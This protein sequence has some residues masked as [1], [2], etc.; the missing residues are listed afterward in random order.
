MSEALVFFINGRQI[1][2]NSPDPG[3]NLLNYLR[4][5]LQLTGTKYGC[6][7]GGCGACTVMISRYDLRT[8][9]IIHES[10]YACLVPICAVHGMAITTVEGIGNANKL[11]PVQERLAK[12]HGSQ[13]GFCSPGM[14]MSMYTLLRNNPQP[15]AMEIEDALQGNLCRCTG[16]RPIL[17]GFQKFAKIEEGC[18]GNSEN[19]CGQAKFFS[20]ENGDVVDDV[21]GHT[22]DNDVGIE[23]YDN[24]FIPFDPSQEPIFPPELMLNKDYH[25]KSVTFAKNGLVWS[26]PT[27]L[28]ELLQIRARNPVAR[29]VS[30]NLDIGLK[31]MITGTINPTVICVTHVP[32]MTN[33]EISG[34]GVKFGASVTLATINDFYR[35]KLC[36]G[37]S[38]QLGLFVAFLEMAKSFGQQ[39]RNK[40]GIGS[41]VMAASPLSDLI[42]IMMAAGC[43][44]NITSSN[45]PLR[46]VP[47]TSAFFTDYHVTAIEQDEVL[48]SVT[49]PFTT[50]NEYCHGYKVQKLLHRRDDSVTALN[51]GMYVAFEDDQTTLKNIRLCFGGV[52]KTVKTATKTTKALI[53]RYWD[54][55]LLNDTLQ[56]LVGELQLLGDSVEYRRSL[57]QGFFFKFYWYVFNEIASTAGID[58]I[59]LNV[60][61]AIEPQ[62]RHPLQSKQSYQKIASGEGNSDPVGRP[63][64]HRSGIQQATG[65]A[66]YCDD[67]TQEKGELHMAFVLSIFAHAK[68]IS[69]DATKALDLPGVKCFLSADDIPRVDNVFAPKKVVY[70]GQLVG[71]IAAESKEIAERAVKVVEVKYE[72]L[73]A[74]ISIKDAIAKN[75]VDPDIWKYETGDVE[76]EFERSDH[77]MAGEIMLGTQE[78]FYMETTSCICRPR[79]IDE[80]EVIC[81]TQWP[82]SLQMNVAAALGVPAHKVSCKVKRIGGAFGGKVNRP[83]AFAAS[84]AVAARKLNRTVRVVLSRDTDM[85]ATTRRVPMMAKYKVGYTTDGRVRALDISIIGNAGGDKTIGEPIEGVKQAISAVDQVYRI[86]HFRGTGAVCITNIPPTGP[87]RGF[88]VPSGNMFCETIIHDIAVKCGISQEQM[89]EVNMYSC[90]DK[91]NHFNQLLNQVGNIRRCWDECLQVSNFHQRRAAVDAY[92]RENRW[93]KRG[94]SIN[95][96]KRKCGFPGGFLNQGGALVQVYTDGSVLISHG[97][98]EM[99]QGLYTKTIQVASRVLHIPIDRIHANETATDKNAN[100][101]ITGGGVG[102]DLFGNAVKIACESIMDK[103]QPTMAENPKGS[104][105]EWVK[106]A[107]DNRVDL[108]ARGFYKPPGDPMNWTERTGAVGYYFAYGCAC[109]EVEVDCLTGDFEVL[110]TDIVVD[111][112]D[113]LNPAL[114]IGQIEGG[115]MQGYGLFTMEE[116]RRSA[117]GELLSLGPGLY[118]IP[119]VKDIP[120]QFNVHLLKGCPNNLGI[121]SAKNVSELTVFLGSSVY[122][123]TKDALYA[124]RAD[125]GIHGVVRLDPPAT[126]EK[127][128]IACVDQFTK[129][130]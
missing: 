18:C 11:H 79:D 86:P 59:P 27:S 82:H 77:V 103:L 75:S 127:I 129:D 83:N 114:D 81:T 105:E 99:G 15:S 60:R 9:Q 19:C 41:H 4:S 45:G 25:C 46:V 56:L 26:R 110:R 126:A 78:H 108:S 22:P 20:K 32:E 109:S 69:I 16:Y 104:W 33:I 48:V 37:Q 29:L 40:A 106:E 128:R 43:S 117:D 88:G 47:L 84:A 67:V 95:P 85:K 35:S 74:I 55:S 61:S 64:M 119:R 125:A 7:E 30:G 122:F 92:N 1:I 53:G 123:A 116:E 50:K 94:I 71:A 34:D 121:Y 107:Y 3:T 66:L 130:M 87:M 113:S 21:K 2:E 118:R 8:E 115:F 38:Y 70:V 44:L 72:P 111:C 12:A 93:K 101:T 96:N 42:P 13:C 120:Q 52:G 58:N 49:F 100:T 31:S 102:S 28:Q 24:K 124:A 5:E 80:M 65:E 89:R 14:V 68:I 76:E 17:E 6:G 23:L 10:V 73:E 57:I 36:Q 91:F 112:G 62:T 98:I 63:V 39:T 51:A 54:E 90:Q 97:G